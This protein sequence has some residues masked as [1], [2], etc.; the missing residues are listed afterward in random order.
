MK[1]LVILFAL[2]IL[3]GGCAT[4]KKKKN[5]GVEELYE[6][7]MKAMEKGYYIEARKKFDRLKDAYSY[8]KYAILAELRIADAYFE[9]EKYE[10]AI[11][12]YEDFREFHPTSEF[13]P[14]VIYQLG[15]CNFKQMLPADRDQS[16]TLKAI[17][18]FEE[19]IKDYPLD[20]Y[21]VLAKEKIIFC[22]QRLAEHEFY[23]GYYYYKTKN[24]NSALGRFVEILNKYP[25]SSLIEK[26]LF[27]LGCCYY[28]I[29]NNPKAKEI[30][31]LLISRYPES[32]FASKAKK[33]IRRLKGEEIKIEAGESRGLIGRIFG[34]LGF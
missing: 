28:H 4:V 26:T 9:E 16:F 31:S 18:Y 25:D 11:Q 14:Y 21:S 22:K 6:E 15:M 3:I 34:L 30:F 17:K 32:P 13:I 12:A 27:Y 2:F 19:L 5:K 20:K 10:E 33:W 7:G 23:I 29:N 24:Y 8:S 1:K